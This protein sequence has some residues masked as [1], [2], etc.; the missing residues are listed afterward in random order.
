M[1]GAYLSS[2]ICISLVLMLIGLATLL[3]TNA[4]SVSD[5]FKEN[6]LVSVVLK[7]EVSDEQGADYADEL[8]GRPYVVRAAFIDREQ[9]TKELESL[10]GQDFLSV[11]DSSPV[12]VSVDLNLQAEYVS[13]D[14]LE[15]VTD[16]LMQDPL[17]EDVQCQ[18]GLVEALNANMHKISLVIVVFIALLLFISLILINN[19]VRLNVFAKRFSISTM[20][21]VGATRSFIRKPFLQRAA[22]QGIASALIAIGALAGI[23]YWLRSAMPQLLEIVRPEVIAFTGAVVLVSGLLICVVGTFFD[24]NKLLTMSKSELYG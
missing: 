2:I 8:S 13:A 17:V 3:L 1:A 14:S 16:W 12:P 23:L 7:P 24:V 19:V 10:L 9:G 15:M 5:Y 20:K 21:L 18:Q 22:V 11:F 4:R 6:L